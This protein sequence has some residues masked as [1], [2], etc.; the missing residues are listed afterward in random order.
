VISPESGDKKLFAANLAATLAQ[1]GGRTLL[2]D[3]AIRVD[4]ASMKC[5]ISE[6]NP[7]SPEFCRVEQKRM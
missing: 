3:N 4:H 7:G 2:V 6:M 1:L 5:F